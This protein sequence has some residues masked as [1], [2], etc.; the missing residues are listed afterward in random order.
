MNELTNQS[1]PEDLFLCFKALVKTGFI[2]DSREYIQPLKCMIDVA[3]I[4]LCLAVLIQLIKN[5]VT[6]DIAIIQKALGCCFVIV[7]ENPQTSSELW[8]DAQE[9]TSLVLLDTSKFLPQEF[10]VYLFDK[11]MDMGKQVEAENVLLDPRISVNHCPDIW[12]I[13]IDRQ[14]KG[15][16]HMQALLLIDKLKTK[17]ISDIFKSLY[18]KVIEK[19][20]LHKGRNQVN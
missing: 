19:F 18:N 4:Q 14:C 5:Q 9:L 3:R 1:K 8:Q 11:Y 12:K 13:Y 15:G 2:F 16:Q 20:V 10:V 6:V 17:C 7:I